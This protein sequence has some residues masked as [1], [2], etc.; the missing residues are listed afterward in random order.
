[1]S[2]HGGLRISHHALNNMHQNELEINSLD[3]DSPHCSWQIGPC[4]KSC[5]LTVAPPPCCIGGVRNSHHRSFVREEDPELSSIHRLCA[6]PGRRGASRRR[7]LSPMEK[8]LPP[9]KERSLLTVRMCEERLLSS[10][11][12]RRVVATGSAIPSSP[13]RPPPWAPPP[14]PYARAA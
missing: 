8:H 10:W 5:A 12:R 1:M 2:L 3:V 9:A 13:P 6:L 4:L 14:A 7:I 11:R